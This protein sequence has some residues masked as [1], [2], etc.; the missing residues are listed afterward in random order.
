MGRYLR[1]IAMHRRMVSAGWR[2][3]RKE[4]SAA[5][6]TQIRLPKLSVSSSKPARCAVVVSLSSGECSGTTPLRHER[7][8]RSLVDGRGALQ[9]ADARVSKITALV[10]L[11]QWRIS[12][13]P[14]VYCLYDLALEEQRTY[15]PRKASESEDSGC[16]SNRINK[17]EENLIIS[18]KG[19]FR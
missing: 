16:S 11:S 17:D 15:D 1:C 6:P 10:E 8:C 2:T 3:C 19:Y 12:S 14:D 4:R 7:P 13:V 18:A 9:S 5:S